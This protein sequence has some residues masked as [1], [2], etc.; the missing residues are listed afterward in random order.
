MTALFFLIVLGSITY[1]IV[2]RVT[3][4]TRTPAWLLWLVAMMPAFIWTAWALFAGSSQ[5]MPPQLIF[6]PFI[7]C[8]LLYWFLIQWGRISSSTADSPSPT[9]PTPEEANGQ[10]AIPEPGNV[11]PISRT[12]EANLQACFPWSVYY[13]QNLEYRA[14]AVI[15]RG[16]LRSKPE[17]AYETIRENV[18]ERFGD[19]FYVVFQEDPTGKPVFVLVPNPRSSQGLSSSVAE[20]SST[21]TVTRPGLAGGLLL[22]TFLTTTAAWLEIASQPL[23]APM[24]FLK[25]LPYA[26]ALLLILGIHELAHYLAARRYRIRATLPYF[27]PVLPLYFFPFGT[28]GAFIQLRSPIPHR[29]ALFDVGIAGPLSGFLIALPLLIWGLFHSQVVPMPDKPEPFNFQAMSPNFSLLLALL[30]KLI[31]GSALT[32]EM[33][34]HLHPVAVAACLGMIVTAFNL[35][36]VGQLDGGHIVHA[37]FGQR[38]G[39][40]IG[41][42]SRLLLLLLSL[43]QPH[44]LLWAI[45]LFLISASDEPALN[46]VTELDNQRDFWGLVSLGILLLIILPIPAALGKWLNI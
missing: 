12:E 30:S 15:C 27:I 14:Q 35:M 34:I 2:R 41:Q 24:D 23:V 32:S 5:P 6:I 21:E 43:A 36:P 33:A 3:G 37:M 13:L 11:R 4:V 38:T 40:A 31:L 46:D 44:L 39:A 22:L 7:T 18:E 29:R 17:V 20:P 8:L 28:F 45:L 9:D 16:Q 26:I 1:L 25:G 10:E 42:I 19:R